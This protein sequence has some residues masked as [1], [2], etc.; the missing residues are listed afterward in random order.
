MK[1]SLSVLGRSRFDGSTTVTLAFERV[2]LR[3][4]LS[5]QAFEIHYT[6]DGAEPTVASP[7]YT[8]P[9]SVHENKLVRA[10]VYCGGKLLTTSSGS[11]T[12]GQTLPPSLAPQ[13]APQGEQGEAEDPL[14]QRQP[15]TP[16][17]P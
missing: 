2:A 13:A 11:F 4:P 3:G 17:N 14:Q 1:S 12:K 7:R 15:Q 5:A 16:K 8:A 10:A 6:I 9:I